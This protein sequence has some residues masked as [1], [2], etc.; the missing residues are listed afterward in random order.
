MKKY[1]LK[2]NHLN[3]FKIYLKKDGSGYITTTELKSM[4]GGGATEVDE[5]VWNTLIKEVDGN[6]DGEVI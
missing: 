4:F 1:I 2:I 3:F 6:G 5:E